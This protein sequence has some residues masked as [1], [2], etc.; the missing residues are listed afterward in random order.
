MALRPNVRLADTDRIEGFSDAVFAIAI[1]LLVLD[2]AIPQPGAF[3]ADLVSDW[4]SYLA[5]LTAF[6][7]IAGVWVH[8]H[9]V[10]TRV[11]RAEP[12][13]VI[14]NVLVLLGVSLIPWPT[15]LIGAALRDGRIAD[16][17]AAIV[18]FAVPSVILA[19]SWFVL[20]R[21]L[22]ARPALLGASDDV[23]FMQRNART[24]MLTLIPTAAATGLAFVAPLGSLAIYLLIST[25]FLLRNAQSTRPLP[26][27]SLNADDSD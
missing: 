5:Y 1:T 13:V 27:G 26:P 16:Q 10:F 7:T 8:H 18:V 24:T 11:V 25:Y 19:V 4:P 20:S 21:A 15:R 17:T 22:A 6:V 2:L 9:T 12:V 23:A 14:L 3:A